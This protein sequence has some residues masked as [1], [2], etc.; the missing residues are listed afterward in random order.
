MRYLVYT[1]A[2]CAA[3]AIAW[4][5][6][7]IFFL[8]ADSD[9]IQITPPEAPAAPSA[10]MRASDIVTPPIPKTP[11][12]ADLTLDD[13]SADLARSVGIAPGDDMDM[14]KDQIRLFLAGEGDGSNAAAA[15]FQN[16]YRSDGRT[17]FFATQ[18]NM[19]DD[20]VKAQQIMAVFIPVSVDAAKLEG[21]GARIKCWRGENKDQWQT[22]LCP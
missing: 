4:F 10:D 1:L 21:Y 15:S 5:L 19:G 13:F 9:D 16:V 8:G 2:G 20:S 18:D 3:L 22:D 12:Y 7:T 11:D 6:A 17:I 14:V